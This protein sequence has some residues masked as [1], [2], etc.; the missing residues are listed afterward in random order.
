MYYTN[1]TYREDMPGI[2]ELEHFREEL[3]RLGNEREVTEE[4]GET[5]EPLPP[6]SITANSAPS[7]D[8]DNLLAGIGESTEPVVAPETVDDA[9]ILSDSTPLP[10]SGGGMV[11]EAPDADSGPALSDF[12][13]LLDSL[14]LD[15]DDSSSGQ[16]DTSAEIPGPDDF[17]LPDF[18][19]PVTDSLEPG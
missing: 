3:T 14:D 7:I 15:G 19:E 1:G 6:P 18:P 13:S 5:Y 16:G 12:D 8:V 9:S 11:P 10:E 4:R 2:K 17:S